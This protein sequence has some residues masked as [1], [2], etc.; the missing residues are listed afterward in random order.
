MRGGAAR[1]ATAPP[2]N[3]QGQTSGQKSN[4]GQG[5]AYAIMPSGPSNTNTVVTGKLIIYSLPVYVLFD[6]NTFFR[7]IRTRFA[8]C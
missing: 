8:I 5:T 7:L 2:R 1:A 6:S 4:A 3:N